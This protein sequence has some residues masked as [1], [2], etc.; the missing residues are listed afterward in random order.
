MFG[1]RVGGHYAQAAAECG[2]FVL[3]AVVRRL[4][5]VVRVGWRG[6]QRFAQLEVTLAYAIDHRDKQEYEQREYAHTNADY[7]RNGYAR[8]ARQSGQCVAK[9]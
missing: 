1:V 6:E 9:V 5:G 7:E 2:L 8:A 4:A 3:F